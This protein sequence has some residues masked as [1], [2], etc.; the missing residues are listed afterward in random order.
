MDDIKARMQSV[1]GQISA[2]GKALYT[3]GEDLAA[4]KLSYG[5]D[6]ASRAQLRNT[7]LAGGAAAG[8][9]ALLL[10]TKTG[11]SIGKT[12]VV[13]GGLGMLGKL[14][15]DAYQKHAGGATSADPAPDAAPVGELAG[16]AADARGAAILVAMIAASKADGHIDAAEKAQIQ[17][18][19]KM[20]DAEAQG[21]LMDELSKPLDPAEVARHA[22]SDQ[23]RREIYAV[24]A[25][26]CSGDD[27]RERDYLDK[28]ATA[29]TLDPAIAAE[30]E[31]EV[32]AA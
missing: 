26:V 29:L 22:D 12:G 31:R 25:M 16:P 23:A 7:A 3:Q 9:M 8:V 5:D 13:L 14:A 17:S 28:L 27:P 11:R 30:I 6:E 15:Y 21:M 19:M 10:G 2:K 20:L 18:Q 24:S 4:Q 32:L 1:L